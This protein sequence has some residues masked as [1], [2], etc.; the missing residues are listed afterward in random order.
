[1]K[2]GIF[3]L[4]LFVGIVILSLG[5]ITTRVNADYKSCTNVDPCNGDFDCNVDADDVKLFLE[6]FGRSQF[7]YPCPTCEVGDWCVYP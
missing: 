6:D 2:K 1:M 4:M 7:F 5:S 3:F